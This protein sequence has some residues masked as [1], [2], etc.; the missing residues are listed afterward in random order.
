MR[1]GI[2]G[3]TLDPVHSGHIQVALEVQHLLNLD[4]MMLLPAGDP[5]HKQRPIS[6]WDRF[7][8]AKLAADEHE[9]LFACKIEVLR[10]GTTYTVDTLEELSKANP[11]TRWYYVVG[12]DTLEILD[13]WR[14]FPRIAQLCEFAVIGRASQSVNLRRIQE[15]EE[16]YGARF[17]ALPINGPDISSTQIRWMVAA[18][19]DISQLV[20]R[21]VAAYI[22][23]NGLY[24]CDFSLPAL[25]QKLEGLL[26][27]AR[28]RHTLGVA[29]TAVRLASRFGVAPK[30]AELAALLH[31]CAKYMPVED[32]R[33]L[34]KDRGLDVDDDEMQNVSVLHAPAGAVLAQTEYGVQDPEILSAIRKHTL[35]GRQMSPLEALIYTADFIEPNRAPFDGLEAARTLAETDLY[36]AMCLCAK[37]TNQY[38]RQGGGLP[39]PRSRAML[40]TYD[41]IG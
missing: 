2:M 34:V 16:Q 10:S 1:V 25:K 4:R 17:V 9:G 30:R 36:G 12:E 40:E 8:M 11:N 18:G 15:L 33:T 19:E 31:D 39:H 28:Y 22:R 27:P 14:N 29:Q 5:P 26:K 13:S 21:S 32:M 24:L 38:V 35:G 6:K 41:K 20:P 3:G 37:L 7:A 23:Q